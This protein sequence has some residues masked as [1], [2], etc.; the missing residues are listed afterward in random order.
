MC[1]L[2]VWCCV[3]GVFCHL[4]PVHGCACSV[5]CVC[6]VLRHLAPVH[7]CARSVCCVC[8]VLEHV[9]PVQRCAPSM[10]SVVCA[11]SLA[12]WLLFTG[13]RALCAVSA[14]SLATWHVFTGVPARCAVCAVSLTTWPLFTGVP[15]RCIVLCVRCPLPRGSCS[16]V[17]P[18]GALCCV[19]CVLGHL[20]P[21]HRCGRL[22]CY[23][24]V[25]SASWFPFTGARSVCCVV[26]SVSLNTSLVITGVHAPCAVCAVS[27]ATWRL[28]PS[29][30]AR[31]VVLCVRCPWPRG[32]GSTVC[33]CSVICVGCCGVL[34]F[35]VSAV[36]VP[37]A[38]P[39]CTPYV[40]FFLVVCAPRVGWGYLAPGLVPWLWPAA[41]ILGVPPGPAFVRPALSGPV[42]LSAPVGLF[43]AVVPSPARGSCP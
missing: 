34:L 29:V 23:V 19:C 42:A 25:S 28:P 32:T 41:C 15:A 17:C 20:A 13:V 3:C 14:M 21:I 7:R 5:C 12:L 11:V 37:C 30:H 31:C 16:P 27:L 36:V 1:P 43:V 2:R 40:F 18:L 6:G 26:G 8:D 22:V 24:F 4:A 39:G 35:F 9:V 10:C 38:Q 33:T